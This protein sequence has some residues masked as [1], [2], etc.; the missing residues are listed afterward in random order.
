MLM[1]LYIFSL[2]LMDIYVNVSQ[3]LFRIMDP[4][5]YLMKAMSPLQ[6]EVRI[7]TYITFSHNIQEAFGLLNLIH[8]IQVKKFC[9]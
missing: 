7:Y 3:F 1:T 2:T 4:F 9:Y 8:G 5:E 6:N